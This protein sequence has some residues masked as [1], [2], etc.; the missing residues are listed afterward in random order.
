MELDTLAKERGLKFFASKI[1]FGDVLLYGHTARHLLYYFRTVLSVLKRHRATLKLKKCKYFQ[2][3]CEF[4]G[5]YV[6]AGG[7]QPAQ[8]KNEAFDKLERTN[9]WGD[10]RII[11]GLF[12]FYSQCLPLYELDIRP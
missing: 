3:R 2:D 9:T 12:V 7:T 4:L 5:V 10:L 11:I 8:S 1:I 6:A